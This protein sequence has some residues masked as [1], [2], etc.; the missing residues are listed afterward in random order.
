MLLLPILL[1]LTATLL[2]WILRKRHLRIHWFLASL[3]ILLAWVATFILG[4][5]LPIELKFSIWKPESLF[6]TPLL[7]TLDEITWPLAMTCLAILLVISLTLPSR[8]IVIPAGERITTL[9]YLF[10]TFSAVL[11]GNI[12]SVLTTW[13]LMDIFIFALSMRA[14]KYNVEDPLLMFWFGKNLI[15]VFLLIIAA[16]LNISGGG[17]HHFE[18]PMIGASV[19]IVSLSSLLRMPIHSIS[20]HG[21][22]IG[23]SDVGNRTTLD[24]FP[25]LSG[26]SVL[27]HVLKNGLPNDVFLW[28][29]LIGGI[30]LAYYAIKYFISKKTEVSRLE[31]YLGVFGLGILVTSYGSI[32]GG[33]LISTVGVMIVSLSTTMEFIK[34]HEG[35]HSFIPILFTGMLAGLP[36]TPGGLLSL[37]IADEILNSGAIGIAILVWIGMSFLAVG[38]LKSTFK[39]P[40][41]WRNSEN[42]TRIS[43]S[44]GLMLLVANTILISIQLNHEF[45]FRSMI[46]FISV[47]LTTGFLYTILNKLHFKFRGDFIER[48]RIPRWM[49]EFSPLRRVAQSFMEIF[50]GI[51][52][53]FESE[54]GMLWAFVILQ[55]L[56]IALGKLNQ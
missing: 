32:S 48:V 11:A 52:R 8:D 34:I 9:I 31:F 28:F 18:D 4:D 6:S 44:V 17:T 36:G 38:Y 45:T 2:I 14:S 10:L 23:W 21:K 13:M 50:Y 47:G 24:I 16:I 3:G 54:T 25:A 39:A 53:I 19:V 5:Q 22:Q 56:I 35:W 20:K 43:Y 29:R 41:D 46:Y 33:I 26:M 27:G 15:S 51:G 40:I 7:F 12:L 49:S 37:R 30:Y 42:L 55:L 1:L